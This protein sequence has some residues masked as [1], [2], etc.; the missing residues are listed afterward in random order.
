MSLSLIMSLF[1]KF[2]TLSSPDISRV[3]GPMSKNNVQSS[4]RLLYN[5]TLKSYP[6]SEK[7]PS[8]SIT[9]SILDISVIF[10]KD[11]YSLS[12]LNSKSLKKSSSCGF[13]NQKEVIVTDSSPMKILH[14]TKTLLLILLRRTSINSI[15]T[16]ISKKTMQKT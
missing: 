12:Q 8:T 9:N 2:S 15:S 11:Y 5:Y 10:S 7:L 3:S 1:S 13:M 6:L 4:S 14:N 16:S